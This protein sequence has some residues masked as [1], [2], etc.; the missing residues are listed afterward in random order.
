MQ[1]AC[2]PPSCPSTLDPPAPLA[3]DAHTALFLDFDGTLADLAERP[4][5]VLVAPEL[6]ATLRSLQQSLQGALAIVSGRPM[7]Q[8]DALLDPLR[9]PL[10]GVHGA[11]RRCADGSVQRVNPPPLD[12][13][14]ARA[15]ALAREI[16]GL[17]V[18]RKPAA[19]A[20]HYR[21]APQAAARCVEVMEGAVRASAGLALL[22]G[23]MVLEAKP[24]G[25]T[26][27]HA[28]EAF[29]REPPFLG[30]RAVFAGDDVTDEAGF[31][32]VHAAGGHTIKVGDGETAARHRMATP[33]ALRAWLA[34]AARALASTGA[35]PAVA[36][37]DP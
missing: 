1:R 32:A 13:V 17:I 22:H 9:L 23:K 36:S 3:L 30:R 35:A 26:K 25:A 7:A 33:A 16:P 6:I 37:T 12:P 2:P 15:E 4:D 34:D 10:A 28:I 8:L 5:E 19:V 20:L 29:L 24:E 21:Q 18:E 31:V 11:E 27:G 14:Q